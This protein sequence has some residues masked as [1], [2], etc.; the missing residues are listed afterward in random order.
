METTV[1]L[2][3]SIQIGTNSKVPQQISVYKMVLEKLYSNV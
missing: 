1:V 3:Y 2:F